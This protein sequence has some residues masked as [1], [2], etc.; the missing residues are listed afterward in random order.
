MLNNAELSSVKWKDL[1]FEIAK[2][3]IIAAGLL[4]AV[5][6]FITRVIVSGPSMSPTLKDGEYLIV[7]K[8]H[9]GELKQGGIV[10]FD[11][12]EDKND[13]LVKRVIAMP[14]DHVTIKGE[15]VFVNGALLYEPYAHGERSSATEEWTVPEGNLFVVGDNRFSSYDSRDWGFLPI[16]NVKGVVVWRYSH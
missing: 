3:A 8:A 12:T 5:N 1:F 6:L 9:G 11:S 14:G 2:T 10:V 15:Q 13:E 16:Q 7:L 4:L